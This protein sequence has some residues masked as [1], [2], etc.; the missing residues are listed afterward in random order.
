MRLIELCQILEI[1]VEATKLILDKETEVRKLGNRIY[2]LMQPQ[3]WTEVL[4]TLKQELGSDEDGMKILTCQLLCACCCYEQYQE[5]KI[6]E[7]IFIDTM[8]FFTRF[9]IDFWEKHQRYQYV[10]AW[11]AVRQISMLEFRIG[12]LEFEMKW[13][14]EAERN[15]IDVHIPGDAN[16]QLPLIH[17]SYL[18]ARNFFLQH[19]PEYGTAPFACSSWLLASSLEKLLPQDSNIIR[20]Q[21]EYTITKVE[22]DSLGFMDWIYGS[23][24]IPIEELP[25][26]TSLQ[27]NVKE[28][29]KQGGK[30]G[31][32]S[33]ELNFLSK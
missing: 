22:E 13:E 9:L 31:W 18:Q 5:K 27:K 17:D 10:W 26:K 14:Q 24:D 21:S 33:G 23:K 28:F 15:V 1:P 20:F 30:I 2:D 16:M 12:E 7:I 32:T 11:W 8:K 3:L 4:E 25:E 6:E 19:Y 29:L